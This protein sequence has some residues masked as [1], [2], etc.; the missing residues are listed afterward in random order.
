MES[1]MDMT[2]KAW[3]RMKY[4]Q[5]KEMLSNLGHSTTFARTKSMDELVQRGG[6]FAARD[7]HRVVKKWQSKNPNKSVRW[8]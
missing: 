5:K 8:D 7:I 2:K 1:S 6:G 4:N 3:A